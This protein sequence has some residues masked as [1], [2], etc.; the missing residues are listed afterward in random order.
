MRRGD[1]YS[2]GAE[3]GV[4]HLICNYGNLPSCQWE[5][6]PL[7]YKVLIPAVL[8][9]YGYGTVAK[10]GLGSCSG[11]YYVSAVV[12]QG[13]AYVYELSLKVFMLHLKVGKG[14]MTPWAPVDQPEIPVDQAILKQPYKDLPD[15]L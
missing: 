2:T 12:S 7:A 15:S 11:H 5:L 8:R 9:V 10:H 6:D 1:L 4:Y 3:P 13:V 14:R